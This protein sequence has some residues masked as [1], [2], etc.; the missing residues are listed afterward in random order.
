[1]KAVFDL[2]KKYYPKYWSKERLDVLL[3]KKKLTQEE[4]DEIT[5]VSTD[6]IIGDKKD[7]SSSLE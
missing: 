1:M 4:Y 6:E 3:A 7:T 5:V 2:A